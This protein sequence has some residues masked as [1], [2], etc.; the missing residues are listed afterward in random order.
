[1]LLSGIKLTLFYLY[2]VDISVLRKAIR[3]AVMMIDG[4]DFRS[5]WLRK[6]FKK[7]HGV[8]VG[9]YSYGA[10]FEPLKMPPGTRVG[11]FCSINFNTAVFS[12]DHELGA[13][14]THPFIFH[15]RFGVV[16]E[17]LSRVGNVII[18]NDVWMGH[19]SA[20]LPGVSRIGDGAVIA[21]GA[22]VTKDVPPYAVVGGVPAKI[23]KYR[24]D[25]GTIKKLLEIRWWDW[26][27]DKILKN[28]ELFRDI[29][30]FVD[31]FYEDRNHV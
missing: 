13:V 15:T 30:G 29:N 6:I 12:Y 7:Y 25:E 18:G 21:A 3:R 9:L 22:V 27:E 2:G 8:E 10:C 28:W 11:R 24:F 5:E 17:D 26:P 20:V 16:K 19:N 23:I 31:R 14:T 1:M 4:G